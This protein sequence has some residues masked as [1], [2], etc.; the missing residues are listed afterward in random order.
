MPFSSL[1][2]VAEPVG[3]GYDGCRGYD[4][5]RNLELDAR[6]TGTLRGGK[7]GYLVRPSVWA[8]CGCARIKLKLDMVHTS[9]PSAQKAETGGLI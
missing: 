8:Q 1:R 2:A 6:L 3:W 4:M 7:P 9:N 5:L